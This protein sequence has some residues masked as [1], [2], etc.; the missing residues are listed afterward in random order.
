[1]NTKNRDAEPKKP[2]KPKKPPTPE[3]IK[4]TLKSFNQRAAAGNKD[5][6]ASVHTMLDRF[7]WLLDD[8]NGL[9]AD[10]MEMWLLKA[11]CG[12]AVRG[13]GYQQEAEQLKAELLGKT[14]TAIEK[15]MVDHVVVSFLALKHA[16]MLD[17]TTKGTDATAAY[18]MKRVVMCQKR[19]MVAMKWLLTVR[20]KMAK[21]LAP[22]ASIKLFNA[23]CV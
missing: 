12:D 6:L 3:F 17:S 7:P 23:E 8:V 16:E 4:A 19:F 2:K 15:L 5:A 18:K 10:A 14:P 9:M 21:G 22:P 11:A 1:M 13:R 20:E